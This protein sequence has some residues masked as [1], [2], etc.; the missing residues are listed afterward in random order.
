MAIDD[1]RSQFVPAMNIH[2]A[3]SSVATPSVTMATMAGT[4]SG[5]SYVSQRSYHTGQFSVMTPHV[6]RRL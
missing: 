4:L 3:R 1:Y 5:W 2:F 6:F